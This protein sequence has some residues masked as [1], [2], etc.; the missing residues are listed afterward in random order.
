METLHLKV[1]YE[2]LELGKEE[3]KGKGKGNFVLKVS[4]HLFIWSCT[5]HL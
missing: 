5:S 4:F 2:K 3:G 1:R